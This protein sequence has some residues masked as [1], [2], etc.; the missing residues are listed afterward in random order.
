[1][2]KADFR[3][4]VWKAPELNDD[5]VARDLPPI[6]IPGGAAYEKVVSERKMVVLDGL[7]WLSGIDPKW[8]AGTKEETITAGEISRRLR[9]CLLRLGDGC[10]TVFAVDKH[11]VSVAKGVTQGKRKAQQTAFS[12]AA[13]MGGLELKLSEETRE[14]GRMQQL[15]VDVRQ[16]IPR[17]MSFQEAVDCGIVNRKHSEPILKGEQR[18][19]EYLNFHKQRVQ[20]LTQQRQETQD[21]MTLLH[22]D[23]P[24]VALSMRHVSVPDLSLMQQALLAVED[25]PLPRP[26]ADAVSGRRDALMR[27]LLRTW[28]CSPS[29]AHLCPPRG[30]VLIVDGHC[31]TCDQWPVASEEQLRRVPPCRSNG[32]V[33]DE[34]VQRQLDTPLMFMH[35]A[36]AREAEVMQDNINIAAWQERVQQGDAEHVSM[37][38]GEDNGM[39]QYTAGGVSSEDDPLDMHASAMLLGGEH[40]DSRPRPAVVPMPKM[41][42][43]VGEADFVVFYYTLLLLMMHGELP[44]I[45]EIVSVDTD[46]FVLGL[47]FLYKWENDMFAPQYSTRGLPLPTLLHTS[48]RGWSSAGAKHGT[49]NITAAYQR[50]VRLIL[51]GDSH[52]IPSLIGAVVSAGG[53]YTCAS[54]SGITMARFITAAINYQTRP[55]NHLTPAIPCSLP[56]TPYLSRLVTFSLDVDSERWTPRV[57]GAVFVRLI[58][59]VFFDT[60]NKAF[61]DHY[62]D[63]TQPWHLTLPQVRALVNMHVTKNVPHELVN[64]PDAVAPGV[65]QHLRLMR[66][67]KKRLPPDEQLR[68]RALSLLH[69]MLMYND[70]GSDHVCQYDLSTLGFGPKDAKE[71]MTRNNIQSLATDDWEERDVKFERMHGCDPNAT[72]GKASS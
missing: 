31:M 36:D 46:I 25:T 57:D 23:I 62:M 9:N 14:E 11:Q 43:T 21:T 47:W 7:T 3:N 53:D 54:Y 58:R 15:P 55:A 50:L 42:N 12:N 45:V 29:S 38:T 20:E 30:S 26:W 32:A 40:A 49:T 64:N 61:K 72:A 19:G 52:R 28:M 56:P 65:T 69:V 17:G 6:N 71:P 33:L 5:H 44:R 13:R 66:A 4:W 51:H 16:M 35:P 59:C 68:V 8:S 18:R 1:M 48:G 60:Y 39:F 70:V 63:A 10:V 24:H 22:S 27:Y 41:Y 37:E 67:L 34:E 2:S